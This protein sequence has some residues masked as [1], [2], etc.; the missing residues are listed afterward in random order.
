MT[1]KTKGRFIVF[2]GIDGSGTST[3]SRRLHEALQA[4]GRTSHLTFEPTAN[5]IGNVIRNLIE[6]TH[7]LPDNDAEGRRLLAMLFAA[8][9]L[10]HLEA[11]TTGIM[12]R[13][14]SG[15]DVVLARYVLSSVAYEGEGTDELA[16]VETLNNPFPCPDLTVYLSCPVEVALE[17]ITTTREKVDVF[18]NEQKLLRVKANYERAIETY[19]GRVLTIEATLPQDEIAT[20]ILAAL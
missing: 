3:Q 11:P 14:D 4:S 5:T 16:F 17:R 6:G 8:D 12:A 15:Q 20:A 18:E 2:E 19:G 7:P 9:R 10:D 13:L 1:N